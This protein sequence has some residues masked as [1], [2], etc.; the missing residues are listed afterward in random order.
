MV[1]R[2]YALLAISCALC[3]TRLDE[4]VQT[5]MRDKY[6][7]QFSKMTKGG[8]DALNAYQELFLY[9]CPKFITCNGPPYHD[10][11]A[12][13][14]YTQSPPLDSM[15]HQLRIFLQDVKT[16]LSNVHIRS[17]LRVY[18]SLGTDKLAGFLDVDEEE[19][20]EMMM[21]LKNSTRS[22]SLIHI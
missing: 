5:T 12:L 22:L 8:E 16:Q 6:G 4:H 15:Q 21:V 17:F 1:D 14:D 19:V 18:T 3:P 10:P 13:K 11:E 9:A 2:M 7:D 20:V